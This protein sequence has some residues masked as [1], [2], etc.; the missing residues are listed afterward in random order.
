LRFFLLRHARSVSNERYV[1]T[2]QT[3]SELSHSGAGRQLEICS[4]CEY[5]KGGLYFSSPLKRC[6]SSLEIVYG[7]TADYFLPEFMEC[8]LGTLEGKKYT[9]L[10]DDANYL[11]WIG[12]PDFGEF[13]G[14]SFNE[15]TGRV[16]RGFLKMAGICDREGIS[17][18]VAV[19]H[20]NVMRAIL[21]RFV[22]SSRPHCFWDI[23][24]CGGYLFDFV[25][26]AQKPPLYEKLPGFLFRAA[27]DREL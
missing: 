5:P 26:G 22:D 24:N 11:R 4:R 19:L 12:A 16:R 10:D 23:P 15:F 3:D 21:H 14:E 18:A 9:N 27:V 6:A 20:G 8:S 13:G 7:R 1:W 2:G 17:S 25:E